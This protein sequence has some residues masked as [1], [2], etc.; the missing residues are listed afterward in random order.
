VPP[1][2]VRSTPSFRVTTLT[3]DLVHLARSLQ[4]DTLEDAWG[5]AVQAPRAEDTDRYAAAID[6]LCEHDLAS[7]ALPM[8]SA[9]IDALAGNSAIDAAMELGFRVLRRSAHN[10]ALVKGVAALIEKRYGDEDWYAVLSTRAGLANGAAVPAI[11][12]FDRLRRFTKGYVVYHAAGWG[13]GC[14]TDFLAPT[15]EVT[16]AF[17]TGR[18]E[19]FPLDTLLSRF[20]PLDANDLRA[21]K[22][23]Q[24]DK[25]REEA[26]KNPSGLLRRVA[27]LYRG[28]I[29]SQQLKSEL[30]PAVITE[31]DWPAYWKR[32]KAAATKD[33]WLRVEG[34]ATRPTFVIREKPVGLV[35]EATV[36]LGHQNDLGQR[37]GVLRDYLARGQDEEVRSQ[38]LTLATKTVE[39]AIEE[40]KATHAHI[41]DGILFLEEHG[42]QASVPAAQELRALLVK[43][44]GSLRPIA[45]DRLATQASREHAIELLPQALGENWAEQ[46][47]V[48]L[49]EWPNSVIENVVNKLLSQNQGVL[50]LPMW[51]RVAPYPKRYPLLTYLLGKLYGD[52]L[53]DAEEQRPSQVTVGRVMLHL[54]RV[55]NEDRKRNI[56][57]SRLLGRLTSL[58]TGKRGLLHRSLDDISREDLTH[59]V[60]IIKRSG[61]DFSQE[62]VDMI[63][64]V[65]AD[66][67][68]DIHARPELPFWEKDY[69]FT[70]REGLRRIKEEY[71]VL[72]E[73]KIPTNSKSIGAAASLGDLSENSEWESAMEEQRNLT[74]R[75]QDMDQQLRNTRLIEDQDV[76]DDRVAPGTKITFIEEVSGKK[77]TYRVLGPWD[78]VDDH[79]I[80]YLAPIAQ[81]LLGKTVGEF[82]EVPGI[83][84]PVRV[85][86]D[87]I[88]RIV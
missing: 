76:P 44:D 22:L 81:G 75:A 46:C 63:D 19:S 47:A 64:R 45:I 13:E 30:S 77:V 42:L 1:P 32:A 51:D 11:L 39:Q 66:K 50:C 6:Q 38:I 57:H 40:K 35:E 61:D 21:M 84:G 10:D 86:I 4:L 60:G 85:R 88:E 54:G 87:V 73:D 36:T 62:I 83:T 37:I 53:F 23:L 15:Q 78:V 8:A 55:L 43:E 59:Y 2:F 27:T 79:T 65:V 69:I 29:T 3:H 56:M 26:E 7:R 24:M 18:R 41:L 68:P 71:R 25:L 52:G 33:P 28:T 82:G 14:V 58:L 67:Y 70:T 72:V 12:E 17:A 48:L 49:T 74:G 5:Q 16:V 20:K 34:S 31:K 9:M 80:N